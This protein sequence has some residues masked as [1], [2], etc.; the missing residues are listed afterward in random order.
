MAFDGGT[1]EVRLV[2][3]LTAF[4]EGL[5]RAREEARRLEEDEITVRIRA[6]VDLAAATERLRRWRLEQELNDIN[7]RVNAD[8]DNMSRFGGAL[9][10]A[11]GNMS[12]LQRYSLLAGAAL[13]ALGPILGLVGGAIASLPAAMGL[14]GA[15]LGT[16]AL[17]IDGI[18]GAYENG[19]K[20]T[21]DQ[22]KA[23][24]SQT[25]MEQL[26]PGF[27]QLGAVMGS[28]LPQF[29][30][31][32]TNLSGV[33]NEM[34]R[35]VSSGRGMADINVIF[36]QSNDFIKAMIG[37]AGSFVQTLLDMGR[38]GSTSLPILSQGLQRASDMWRQMINNAIQSGQ[39]KGATDM[40][41]YSVSGL[42][43]GMV[44]LV[45]MMIQIASDIGPRLGQFFLQ[46]GQS[47]STLGPMFGNLSN[48]ALGA[49]QPLLQPAADIV[50]LL[51]N[52]LAAALRA[53][54]PLF[55]ALAPVISQVAQILQAAMVPAI[56]ALAPVFAQIGQ[57]LGPILR[58]LFTQLA[59]IIS[60]LAMTFA[61]VLKE[62]S[63]LVPL[64]GQMVA[65][66]LPP[67]ASA[68][69]QVV[70]AMTP[71]IPPIV[72]LAQELLPPLAQLF[73]QLVQAC[74]P[75]I[76]PITQ[77]AK[78]LL[79]I[80]AD[81]I[82]ALLPV[83]T[84]LVQAFAQIIQAIAPLI[85][86]IS[87]ALVP[88]FKS[89]SETVKVVADAVT[90]IIKG[91]A[92][93]IS[94]ALRL[95]TDLLRGDWKAA[96]E[97][98]KALLQGVFDALKAT[99]QGALNIINQSIKTTIDTVKNVWNSGW[100]GLKQ[101]AETAWNNVSTWMQGLPQQ[102]L[103]IFNQ[104]PGAMAQI[105][106]NIVQ[107][108]WNGISA[109]WNWLTSMVQQK[110]QE[111]LAAAKSAIGVASPS[112]RF[113]LEVGKQIPAG[114]AQGIQR[115]A[116]LAMDALNRLGV[117]LSIQASAMGSKVTGSITGGSRVSTGAAGG[118]PM[119]RAEDGSYVPPSF[120]SATVGPVGQ[121]G[122]RAQP[123][124]M[125]AAQ[126]AAV[127]PSVAQRSAN[128]DVGNLHLHLDGSNIQ[129]LS[130]TDFR[131]FMTRVQQGLRSL[132]RQYA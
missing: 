61:N 132:E 48:A 114:I 96:W 71:L 60:Q 43:Q 105:G 119:I 67:L 91:L 59:P 12:M 27:R 8:V 57:Q 101:S 20:P 16:I 50:S 18:K 100:G 5:R 78:D 104:L 4:N 110:A 70:Q 74:L 76:P 82:R 23:A 122:A 84:S 9:G 113:E 49:L 26:T 98:T 15:A 56:N 17:G 22:M 58:D 124:P 44:P 83:I 73:V 7:I 90:P 6:D 102:V 34:V 120:Y 63:P 128:I 103:N 40:L 42:V 52:L 95:V 31:M 28:L 72:Q 66:I 54:T 129:G 117:N 108:I 39:L 89:I 29:T 55:T 33:F 14:F 38:V 47:L 106:T 30:T 130:E 2:I 92:D 111:L 109:G 19:L 126:T 127:R 123:A 65:T 87:T 35:V 116:N 21:I 24:I 125:V 13:V 46:L 41:A 80:L 77:L 131:N 112:I 62:I 88:A 32:A 115:Y 11:A 99:V 118:Q 81:I 51:G 3:D 107:G 68:F 53:V 37:P 94:A 121:K 69:L 97:D 25:F 86:Q 1:I 36:R 79:P 93:A 10:G 45:G 64:L 85:T 75:L